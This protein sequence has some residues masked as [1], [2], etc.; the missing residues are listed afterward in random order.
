MFIQ[1]RQQVLVRKKVGGGR[2]KVS[3]I[4]IQ[5][6]TLEWNSCGGRALSK[7]YW[8]LNRVEAISRQMMAATAF[9][10]N[11]WLQLIL[12]HECRW[13]VIHSGHAVEG[14]PHPDLWVCDLIFPLA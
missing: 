3:V 8:L 6:L 7:G 14:H 9:D 13:Q 5:R 4:I 10:T 2:G 11:W 12:A 1:A